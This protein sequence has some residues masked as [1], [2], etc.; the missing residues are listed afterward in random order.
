MKTH[1]LTSR[2]AW[3]RHLAISLLLTLLVPSFTTSPQTNNI[4]QLNLIT[5]LANGH[6]RI[7]PAT[8]LAVVIAL[9]NKPEADLHGWRFD[10]SIITSPPFPPS[11]SSYYADAGSIGTPQSVFQPGFFLPQPDPNSSPKED[12]EISI[13]LS[14][15]LISEITNKPLNPLKHLPGSFTFSYTFSIGPWCEFSDGGR[16]RTYALS[17]PVQSGSF[18]ITLTDSDGD[19]ASW[20]DLDSD[21]SSSPTKRCASAV[22]QVHFESTTTAFPPDTMA[23]AGF[24]PS[25]ALPCV[26]TLSLTK[27]ELADPCR[28]NVA[29]EVRESI[30][31]F[32][33]WS[34]SGDG[35]SGD[36]MTSSGAVA[37][38]TGTGTSGGVVKETAKVS[39][40]A[41]CVSWRVRRGLVLGGIV[42]AVL[43][44]GRV[45][46]D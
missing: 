41:V 12:E 46:L 17:W 21:P 5:P 24:W 36:G 33:S 29:G 20:P 32:M 11:S 44:V 26:E 3:G 40:G 34:S 10:W 9:Q 25:T 14:Y 30:S 13:G 19:D 2:T 6:Y 7:N 16:N 8:G 39:G 31:N 23:A 27:T 22:G 35:G 37:I 18:D 1:T 4:I 42:S 15:P 38:G 43:S 28:V 45:L